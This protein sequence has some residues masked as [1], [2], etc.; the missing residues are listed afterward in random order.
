MFHK[1]NESLVVLC[2]L[3]S[4]WIYVIIFNISPN[5]AARETMA[6]A[7]S[8]PVMIIDPGHGGRDGGAVSV[9]GTVESSINWVVSQRLWDMARFMG[10][11]VIMTRTSEAINYPAEL[12][13]IS[14]CKKWDTRERT[15]LINSVDNGVLVSIHQNFFPTPQ[16]H[17]AQVLYAS[18]ESSQQLGRAMQEALAGALAPDNRRVATPAPKNNYILSH[19]QC[20]AI[21]IECGFISNREE[22]LLLESAGYQ[23]KLAAVITAQFFQYTGDEIL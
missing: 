15:A 20:P 9:T 19:V 11:P 21:L 14:A 12:T 1:G 5:N 17:G 23:K 22:A 2:A 3:L 18:T 13:T 16:P 6:A 4:I 7:I 10:I 8:G